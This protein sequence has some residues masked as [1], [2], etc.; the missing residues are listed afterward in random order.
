MLPWAPGELS[1]DEA[2]AFVDKVKRLWEK[3]LMLKGPASAL[4]VLLGLI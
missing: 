3:V 1:G 2:L 4:D